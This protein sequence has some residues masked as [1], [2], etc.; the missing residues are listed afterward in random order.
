[1]VR[2]RKAK[3]HEAVL[4]T[5]CDV[6]NLIHTPGAQCPTTLQAEAVQEED[7]ERKVLEKNNEPIPAATTGARGKY[8]ADFLT[9]GYKYCRSFTFNSGLGDQIH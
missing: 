3:D 8:L 9:V 5:K 6:C 7:Q 1:M 4:P 2:T